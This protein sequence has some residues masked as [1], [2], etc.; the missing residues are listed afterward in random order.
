MVQGRIDQR[1]TGVF[2]IRMQAQQLS[3]LL[4]PHRLTQAVGAEQEPVAV[5][6]AEL[7]HL[8]P[9]APLRATQDVGYDMPPAVRPR[10]LGTQQA[11]PRPASASP[12]GRRVSCSKCPSW[13]K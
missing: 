9:D 6:E 5:G 3:D 10:L 13:N 4:V 2:G 11:R 1:L 7:V 12:Y 8:A